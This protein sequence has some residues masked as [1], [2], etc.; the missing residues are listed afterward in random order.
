[1]DNQ[2]L[3]RKNVIKDLGILIDSK[4]TFKHHID[5][6]H[7][8]SMC[9]LGF[10]KRRSKE[11]NDPYIT[12]AIYCSLIRSLLEYCSVVWSPCYDVDIKKH[13]SVKKHFLL[14]ALR[15]LGWSTESLVLPRYSHRLML[16]D[17]CSLRNRRKLSE[18]LFAFDLFKG[19]I[20]SP[21]LC[22]KISTNTNVH[23]LRHRKFLKE[24]NSRTNYAANEPFNRCS[25]T[26]NEHF[27]LFSSDISRDSFK[28]RIMQKMMAE[29]SS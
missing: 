29:V 27:D 7:S 23:N 6:I 11:F 1:M 5:K 28:K 17:M 10:V 12:K 3:V 4:L 24:S 2:I 18:A 19:N 15:D 22:S 14:F 21:F 20:D 25:K 8:K 16:I 13:E 9:M 26:F